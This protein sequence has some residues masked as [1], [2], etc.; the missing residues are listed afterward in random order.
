MLVKSWLS[1]ARESLEI[2]F[3]LMSVS[4]LSSYDPKEVVHSS[5]LSRSSNVVMAKKAVENQGV[6]AHTFCRRDRVAP[7]T[8]R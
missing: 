7:G 1:N 3:I 5:C 4:K 8:W 2:M 6:N